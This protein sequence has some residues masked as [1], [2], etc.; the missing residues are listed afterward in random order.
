MAACQYYETM[1]V[2]QS[3]QPLILLSS[4]LFSSHNSPRTTTGCEYDVGEE[5]E[6][7]FG[8]PRG[9]FERGRS[10]GI[11]MENIERLVVVI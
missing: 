8:V 3:E 6:P 1:L 4:D 7:C 9:P 5:M 11:G 10:D 2:D